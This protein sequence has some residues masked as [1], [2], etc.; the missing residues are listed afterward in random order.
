MAVSDYDTNPNNN[1]TI[2]GTDVSEGCNPAGINNAIRQLM[3]DTKTFYDDAVLDGDIGTDVQA[4]SANLQSLAG[5]TLAA[6]KGLRS[7]GA[8]TVALYDLTDYALTLLDDADAAAAQTTLDVY[9]KAEVDAKIEAGWTLAETAY[10][11]SVNGTVASV[12]LSD[13]EDGYTYEIEIAR[14]GHNSGSNQGLQVEI[15]GETA[16][17]YTTPILITAGLTNPENVHSINIQAP[18]VRTARNHHS[19]SMSGEA[20]SAAA[21]T[22]FAGS[23]AN[24]QRNIYAHYATAQKILKMR[25]SFQAGS[26]DAGRIRV[27]RKY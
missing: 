26:I 23:N 12:E 20:E 11:S 9:S 25:F 1:S 14:L 5:L 8:D 17:A 7:T 15:Y 18:M 24:D 16:A 4:Y 3:A 6:N 27:W 19:I 10:D 2:S 21:D 22:S 13:F